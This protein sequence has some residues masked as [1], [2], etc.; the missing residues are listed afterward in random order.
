M[1]TDRRL[2]I[3]LVVLGALAPVVAGLVLM[4]G[5]ATS[6]DN[7]HVRTFGPAKIVVPSG[8]WAPPS[9]PRPEPEEAFE[10]RRTEGD[11]VVAAAVLL[12]GTFDVEAAAVQNGG[13]IVGRSSRQVGP[14]QVEMVE[15]TNVSHWRYLDLP[16]PSAGLTVSLR[17]DPRRGS[18]RQMQ[19]ILDG[20]SLS[21]PSTS[22]SPMFPTNLGGK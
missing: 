8:W 4:S 9:R 14:E 7:Q 1:V 17:W 6:G 15:S 21:G 19:K 22:P 11:D 16:V 20:L 12:N 2:R 10:L 13:L 3:S 5:Q 18:G